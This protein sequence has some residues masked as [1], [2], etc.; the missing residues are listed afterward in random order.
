[1]GVGGG[2]EDPWGVG[3]ERKIRGG[4]VCVCRGQ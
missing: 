4:G 1:M 3:G 2:K